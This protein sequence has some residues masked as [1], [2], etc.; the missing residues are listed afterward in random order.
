M[1][2]FALPIPANSRQPY[3]DPLSALGSVTA[4]VLE[5]PQKYKNQVIPVVGEWLTY[6]ELVDKF[7]Q[8]TGVP[9]R[10]EKTID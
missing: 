4:A 8:V 1:L 3:A 9:A 6:T 5:D 7:T 10:Y 2:T